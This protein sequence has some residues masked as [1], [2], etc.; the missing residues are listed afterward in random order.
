V[1]VQVWMHTSDA[2]AFYRLLEPAR[3]LGVD[4][5]EEPTS[6]TADT[7]VLNR[8][9][10]PEHADQ[11]EEWVAE[12]RRV[13]VDMDDDFDNLHPE[14]AIYGRWPTDHLHRACKAASVVTTTTPALAE[15]YGKDHAAVLPNC[16]PAEMIGA[17]QRPSAEERL[18]TGWYGS[19]GAHPVD[20]TVCGDGVVRSL[21]QTGTAFAFLGPEWEAQQVR[22][23]LGWPHPVDADGSPQFVS[24]GL[25]SRFGLAG[26]LR[27][28]TVGL[29]PLAPISFNES[30]SWLKGIEL[31]AV[32]VPVI[33]SPT[34]EYRRL[35]ELDGCL[36]ADS[37]GEWCRILTKLL[38]NPDYAKERAVR[39]Q[40]AV[41]DF[42]YETRAGDWRSVWYS[43][44]D[45]MG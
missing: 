17:H 38:T 12:G 3:V 14:H 13:I 25:V 36:L 43:E 21:Q 22:K 35:A 32:G 31:A 1:T 42:T 45:R 19:L 6:I 20:L 5:K 41:R 33:A 8:P 16:V 15:L 39:G 4:V 18:W 23:Q 37:P 29:V 24:L 2:S 28:F 10:H 40:S 27:E 26:V 7:V 30:K 34:P 44:L 11:V 9:I